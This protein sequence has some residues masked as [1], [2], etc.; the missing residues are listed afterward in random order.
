MIERDELFLAPKLGSEIHISNRK[1]RFGRRSMHLARDLKDG[2]LLPFKTM[3]EGDAF[4][5]KAAVTSVVT[6][7]S[8]RTRTFISR[9]R[10]T[11]A[12]KH[13]KY[14]RAL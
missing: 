8:N 5:L 4:G 14:Q 3:K 7:P 2:S 13:F 9:L 1:R 11:G 10:K 12:H 6:C